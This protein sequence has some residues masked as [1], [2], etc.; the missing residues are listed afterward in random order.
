MDKERP[1]FVRYCPPASEH[2]KGI[3]IGIEHLN[4]VGCFG[5]LCDRLAGR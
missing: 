5:G 3:L 2:E 1:D 4:D